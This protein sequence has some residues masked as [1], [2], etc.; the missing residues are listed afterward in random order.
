MFMYARP[1]C[2]KYPLFGSAA[3]TVQG[4]TFDFPASALPMRDNLLL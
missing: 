4:A 3:T 1:K 2:K